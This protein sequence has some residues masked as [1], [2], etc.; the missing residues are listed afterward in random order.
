MTLLKEA[1][2]KGVWQGREYPLFAIDRHAGDK[3]VR[4]LNKVRGTKPVEARSVCRLA[5]RCVQSADWP[6]RI[7]LRTSAEA[8]FTSLRRDLEKA[9]AELDAM[10]DRS[11]ESP[12]MADFVE[13]SDDDQR[14]PASMVSRPRRPEP[15]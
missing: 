11:G 2:L 3:V 4:H 5:E 10:I 12:E 15:A 9:T 14:D 6:A 7:Y 8:S 1:S 13:A